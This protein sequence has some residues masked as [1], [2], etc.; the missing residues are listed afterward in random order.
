MGVDA[1]V[2]FEVPARDIA[3]ALV[4]YTLVCALHIGAVAIGADALSAPT[5]LL[6]MPLLGLAATVTLRRSLRN[7]PAGL[8]LL[9]LLFSWIGDSALIYFP[10][11]PEIPMMV[12][13]FGLAHAA[14]I[15]LFRHYLAIRPLP[16]VAW[17]YLVWW[18]VFTAIF[19]PVLLRKD[20]GALWL[21]GIATYGA[22]LG[23]TAVFSTACGPFI[24]WGGALFLV[25]DSLLAFE[26]FRPGIFPPLLT[27][28]L[29]MLLYCG[30]QLLMV[31]GA[32]RNR[33]LRDG[34]RIPE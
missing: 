26:V 10:L 19:A 34:V 16:L 25:S 14:Y 3:L 31:L 21:A 30:A 27:S 18:L 11:L 6:L 15:Y 20:A 8:L 29:V 13:W 9:A 28:T 1:D 32:V 22:L 12:T 24:G 2:G 7:V 17:G 33:R 5:K 4:P 23:A